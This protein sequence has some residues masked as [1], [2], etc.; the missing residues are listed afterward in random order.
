MYQLAEHN[1]APGSFPFLKLLDFSTFLELCPCVPDK[2]RIEGPQAC[3]GFSDQSSK[4]GVISE[5]RYEDFFDR[6]A[7]ASRERLCSG[8]YENDL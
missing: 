3:R 2:N 4:Q 6:T 8:L 1:I 5:R 7:R